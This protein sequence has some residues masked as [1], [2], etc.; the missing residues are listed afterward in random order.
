MVSRAP[1][2]A[3]CLPRRPSRR[4]WAA[5][6][7]LPTVSG[8]GFGPLEPRSGQSGRGASSRPIRIKTPPPSDGERRRRIRDMRS[9]CVLT[10]EVCTWRNGRAS[11]V[12]VTTAHAGLRFPIFPCGGHRDSPHPLHAGVLLGSARM[13]ATPQPSQQERAR[14]RM[15]SKRRPEVWRGWHVP[16]PANRRS[17][18]HGSSAWTRCRRRAG[19]R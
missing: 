8:R 14:R 18:R 16:R 6:T 17:W 7:R 1:F 4:P 2:H 3:S 9:D 12:R 10:D 19:T 11:A 15:R 13:P 5:R